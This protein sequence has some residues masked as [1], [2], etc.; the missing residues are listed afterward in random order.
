[1]RRPL[2]AALALL[3]MAACTTAAPAPTPAAP[4]AV[5]ARHAR[6]GDL[7]GEARCESHAQCRTIGV[8]AKP[9]GGP[10]TYWAWSTRDTD[11]KALRQAVEED[12]RLAREEIAREGLMSNCAIVPEPQVSCSPREGRSDGS[13]SC[14][15]VRGGSS[16]RAD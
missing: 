3:S 13:R 2:F 10:A 5:T 11:E 16:K 14:Q 12:A 15:L 8:G 7:I 9:C 4:L 1:M 6:I